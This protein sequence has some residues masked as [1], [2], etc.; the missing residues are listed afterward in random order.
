MV[1]WLVCSFAPVLACA[2]PNPTFMVVDRDPASDSSSAASTLADTTSTATT[3]IVST[4]S[5]TDTGDPD[6]T[7]SF[8][9]TLSD[10]DTTLDPSTSSSS[11]SGDDTSTSTGPAGPCVDICGTPGCGD[12]PTDPMVDFGGFAIDARETRNSEYQQFL[13]AAQSPALQPPACAWNDDYTPT[14]WPVVGDQLPVVNIDWCD[15]RAYCAWAGKRLCGAIDGGPADIAQFVDPTSNQWYRACSNGDG[16]G[17]PYGFLYNPLAC[18]GAAALIGHPID[19]G[20]RPSC[21]APIAGIF[22]LSGNVWEWVDTCDSD[23]PEANCARRG[24]SFFS[25][26]DDLRC[27]LLSTRPRATTS[28]YVGLRCCSL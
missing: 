18:N 2:A 19:V 15:A 23:Q 14:T 4:L 1:R 27:N 20:S 25:I 10:T 21:E 3:S 11:S 16:R 22:D 28:G 24:G 13:A 8:A 5:D 12:C 6:T 7:Q 9:T 17:Y 26:A